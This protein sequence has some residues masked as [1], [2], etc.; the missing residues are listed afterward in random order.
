MVK[1]KSG[2]SS[3][4][5]GKVIR[6]MWY[7]AIG[8]ILFTFV[9]FTAI[10]L[11]MLGKMPTFEELENPKSNL[12]T[13]IISSDGKI[14]G[15]YFV[16]NR[17]NVS[18]QD[19]SPNVINALIATEDAR[20]EG[21]SG[22][23]VKAIFRVVFGVVTG[24]SRGGGSTIT[25]QLAKN[26][27]PRKKDRNFLETA[28]IKFKEWVTAIKLERNYSKDEILAMYLNTV[29]FGSQSFG[30]K[31]AAKTYFNKMPSE[32]T[33]EESA[34]LV[35]M[36]KAP[37]WFSPVRNPERSKDR[38][39]T[40]LYL[41]EKN[42]Y[43]TEQ[44]YDSIKMLPLDMSNFRIQDHTAGLATY[45]REYLRGVLSDWCLAHQKDDGTPYN[46]YRDGLRIYTTI[47]SKMQEYAEDAVRDYL[48]N[49][50]QPQFFRHWKNVPD[51]P[52]MFEKE[53]K[54]EI[55]NLMTQAM[56]R[57]D[58]YYRLKTQNASEAQI[59]KSFN[60]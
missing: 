41:M 18:Y 43:L 2:L 12:A 55:M 47:N 1:K 44:E 54:T 56:R 31:S 48:G 49:E 23:D 39:N 17:S 51:A 33:A 9:L 24:T 50:L 3:H 11:G 20:F 28:I 8:G 36:L 59:V 25:Q 32:L 60:T 5:Q 15:K 14:L 4:T 6:G 21:H 52:F 42:D 37:T 30:I 53:K 19:L 13:E 27:F 40:V 22:V 34:T 45:F 46:L 35:G 58:R 26:L 38:R 57:S 29:D 16:E 10:S 7:T